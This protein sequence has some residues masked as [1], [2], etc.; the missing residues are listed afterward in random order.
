ME[1]RSKAEN[2]PASPTPYCLLPIS[3]EDVKKDDAESSEDASGEVESLTAQKKHFREK[4]E[5]IQEEFDAYKKDNPKV[6]AKVEP[7][8]ETPDSSLPER[9]SDKDIV[10]HAAAR[11]MSA[12]REIEKCKVV[13][14]WSD[15]YHEITKMPNKVIKR[16]THIY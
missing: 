14:N 2:C 5:K 4:S 7:K 15:A 12:K 8:E 11:W 13:D 1:S 3:N 16:T 10:Y 9:L 6:E